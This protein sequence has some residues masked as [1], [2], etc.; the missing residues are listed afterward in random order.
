MSKVSAYTKEHQINAPLSAAILRQVK[1][2]HPAEPVGSSSIA[3]A[4]GI[5]QLQGNSGLTAPT[6]Q[7]ATAG[8]QSSAAI[9]F[10]VAASVAASAPAAVPVQSSN[11]AAEIAEVSPPVEP[12]QRWEIDAA[13]GTL[14]RALKR[15]AERADIPLVW[16]APKDKAALRAAY[17]GTFDEAITQV[18]VD[19]RFSEYRLHACAFDNVI[20]IIHESQS[21]KR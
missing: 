15:W 17:V 6:N 9:A 18:M 10:P 12:P 4:N 11:K 16:D 7:T 2:V 14:S 21:C 1:E 20:R 13:D 5:P 8:A 19:T 3:A